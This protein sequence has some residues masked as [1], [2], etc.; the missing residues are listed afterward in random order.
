MGN[1]SIAI[2]LNSIHLYKALLA[3]DT[4]QKRPSAKYASGKRKNLSRRAVV[5]EQPR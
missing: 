3:V 1:L 2:L 5:E 4:N